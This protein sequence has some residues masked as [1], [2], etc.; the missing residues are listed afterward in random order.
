MELEESLLDFILFRPRSTRVVR[1]CTVALDLERVLGLVPRGSPRLLTLNS[2]WS[3]SLTVFFFFG[4]AHTSANGHPKSVSLIESCRGQVGNVLRLPLLAV[5]ELGQGV[6]VGWGGLCV[7]DTWQKRSARSR[8]GPNLL[9]WKIRVVDIELLWRNYRT[10]GTTWH[11][12]MTANATW[13]LLPT[14]K[15]YSMGFYTALLWEFQAASNDNLLLI[16]SMMSTKNPSV[17]L[18]DTIMNT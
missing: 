4:G 11:V 14:T 18:L 1:N 16:F 8:P 9:G 12:L 6:G 17:P 10:D 3:L 13:F 5:V 15:S 2:L 7:M